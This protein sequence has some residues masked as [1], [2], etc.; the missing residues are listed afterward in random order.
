MCEHKLI[1]KE[2]RTYLPEEL[3]TGPST[4]IVVERSPTHILRE[5]RISYYRILKDR[6]KTWG[7]LC[8]KPKLET[9]HRIFHGIDEPHKEV[10]WRLIQHVH[11]HVQDPKAFFE[12]IME[13]AIEEKTRF[14]SFTNG[15]ELRDWLAPY[16]NEHFEN[17]ALLKL[18]IYVRDG[19]RAIMMDA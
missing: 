16:V 9:F 8:S 7:I 18:Y 2:P 15:N 14:H 4:E 5:N 10:F 6:V 12:A 1:E 13:L 17:T 3:F 11:Y 19:E